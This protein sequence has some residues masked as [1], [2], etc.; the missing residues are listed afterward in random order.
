MNKNNIDVIERG[1]FLLCLDPSHPGVVVHSDERADA[2]S[3]VSSRSLHGNGTADS[4][5]NRWFDQGIQ[6]SYDLIGLCYYR[7][8][9]NHVS[10]PKF[11]TA[12]FV[13]LFFLHSS[14][15]HPHF[16]CMTVPPIYMVVCCAVREV[17]T[18]HKI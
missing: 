15:F 11:F 10:H 12:C 17:G 1:Q 14:L 13:L 5:C 16:L 3:I 9:Y 8:H 7:S 4:S 18:L 2:L 6:V